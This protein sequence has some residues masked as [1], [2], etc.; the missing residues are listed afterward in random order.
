MPTVTYVEANG[1]AHRQD[2]A[3]SQSLMRG[4]VINNIPGIVAECGGCCSCATC[5]V[6]PE[7]GWR[8]KLPKQEKDEAD[9]LGDLAGVWRL[10]CQITVTEALDGLVVH[11]PENQY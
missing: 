10:S 7:P 1:K 9:L 3:N 6:R 5:K 2:V 4:A 11:M 8:E